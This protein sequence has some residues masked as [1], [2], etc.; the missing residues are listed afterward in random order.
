MRGI[1][2]MSYLQTYYKQSALLVKVL[3][4][5]KQAPCFALKGGTAINFFYQ[6]MPR[7]SVDIDI[8]Y[9][10][11]LARDQA[12]T[13][14]N[15]TIA[16]L[17]HLIQHE[18]PALKVIVDK[19]DLTALPKIQ[20]QEQ[21]VTIKVEVNPVFRGSVFEPQVSP[22]CEKAQALFK[23]Y[24]E[25][26]TT[27]PADLYA[28]KFCAALNRQ[29]P[30]DLFDVKLFLEQG[31][32]TDEVRQAFIIYTASDRRPIH[33]ILNPNIKPYDAQQQLHENEFI[34]MVDQD[35]HYQDLAGIVESLAAALKQQFTFNEKQFLLSIA[36]GK[37]LWR[38]MP[39]AHLERLP[40][41]Q[42]KLINIQKMDAKKR[43]QAYKAL[44]STLQA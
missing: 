15:K 42:W 37:P 11:L 35:I 33:E 27:A 3:P 40:A 32:I 39:F 17:T 23:T 24:V 36:E 1:V 20:I 4:F 10:P 21:S 34:G 31:E 18:H 38:L 43:I 30:R 22:L 13:E 19:S 25:I 5:L 8:A 7:L 14:I 44:E 28:G 29:H 2:P 41:L 26:K 9:L 16:T 6:N 12:L